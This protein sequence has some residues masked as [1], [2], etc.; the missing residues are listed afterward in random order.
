MSSLKHDLNQRRKKIKVNYHQKTIFY[1]MTEFIITE[2]FLLEG[3][4]LRSQD[5]SIFGFQ[6]N[7]QTSQYVT[8]SKTPLHY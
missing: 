1:C 2:F 5:I 4:R 6:V 7:P 3:K 8:S